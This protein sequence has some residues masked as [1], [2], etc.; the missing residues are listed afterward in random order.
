M[1]EHIWLAAF[2]GLAYN[3]LPLLELQLKPKESRPDF[4]DIIYWLPYLIWPFMS[5]LLAYAYESPQTPL[6]KMLALHI[7]LSAPLIF[8]QLVQVLPFNPKK[9]KLA[10][11]NQ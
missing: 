10:D 3:I 7:G 2:G 8:R 11:R 9:V 1:S 5:G 4:K 6:N